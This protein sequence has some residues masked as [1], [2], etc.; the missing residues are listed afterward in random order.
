MCIYTGLTGNCLG[1]AP[2]SRCGNAF[3][4]QAYEAQSE[5]IV[6]LKA[7]TEQMQEHLVKST[8]RFV[9]RMA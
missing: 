3:F 5:Y 7:K 2:V 8:A 4:L 6:K 1:V 9:G